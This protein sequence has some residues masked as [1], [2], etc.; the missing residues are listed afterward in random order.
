MKTVRP[1]WSSARSWF[2]HI[3]RSGPLRLTS[4]R[5][6]FAIPLSL[7]FTR[8]PWIANQR[9]NVLKDAPNSRCRHRQV[10]FKRGK[11]AARKQENHGTKTCPPSD[12]PTWEVPAGAVVE[13]T[14]LLKQR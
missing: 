11:P 13:E 6:S 2:L 12:C 9:T 10:P 3:V 8:K 14:L 7:A 4:V 1:T 5:P